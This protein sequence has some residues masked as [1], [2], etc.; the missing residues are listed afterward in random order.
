VLTM[1]LVDEIGGMETDSS[2]IGA[3]IEFLNL[4]NNDV[5]G[6]GGYDGPLLSTVSDLDDGIAF[7]RMLCSVDPIHFDPHPVAVNL[8][9]NW[10][11]KGS[12]LR[13]LVRNLEDYLHSPLNQSCPSLPSID[14][15]KISRNAD[16]PNIISLFEIIL[17]AVISSENRNAVVSR[18][19]DMT[20][21]NQASMKVLIERGM[22]GLV[23]IESSHEQ[24]NQEPVRNTHPVE[25]S[26]PPRIARNRRESEEE[27]ELTFNDSRIDFSHQEAQAAVLKSQIEQITIERDNLQSQ[28]L[29]SVSSDRLQILVDDLQHRLEISR[30]EKDKVASS[31][32][33]FKRSMEDVSA[34]YEDLLVENGLLADELDVARDRAS[35]LVKAE[36]TSQNLRRQLETTER[37]LTHAEEQ[38]ER[39][40]SY[41]RQVLDLEQKVQKMEKEADEHEKRSTAAK[42]TEEREGASAKLQEE[43]R[44]LRQTL[45]GVE[46]EKR[47]AKEEIEVLKAQKEAAELIKGGNEAVGGDDWSQSMNKI[48]VESKEQIIRLQHENNSQKDQFAT[49]QCA[50]A[51]NE[52]SFHTQIEDL[53]TQLKKRDSQITALASDKQK[54]ES[55]TKKTLHKFQEKYLVALQECKSKLKT[56]HD[57]IQQLE[58]RS[59]M[60][61]MATK[62]EERLL[63]SA[64]FE[65]GLGMIDGGGKKSSRVKT[66]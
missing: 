19:M 35:Q 38:E 45:K 49:L 11:L 13:K 50:A 9:D 40:N 51:E 64:I 4:F 59:Q 44:L 57:Y 65:L 43:M 47:E 60:E 29:S 53:T 16:A 1:V 46:R 12:N 36:S 7:H 33:V 54:L 8:G 61:K 39:A 18:I 66:V 15:S 6:G 32:A 58:A 34:K 21:E 14:L 30:E 20:Q 26:T 42:E 28:L 41:Y 31:Q 22:G 10:A 37:R 2:K 24:G 52:S 62:R 63:S 17:A 3:V 48:V 5:S 27:Q 23:A 25:S 55:Y 56:K